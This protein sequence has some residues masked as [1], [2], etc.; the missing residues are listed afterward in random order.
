M[1]S[2]A[3]WLRNGL[4]AAAL[5]ASATSG[6]M[7]ADYLKK[8]DYYKEAPQF[9]TWPDP[10][11]ARYEIS[12]IGPIGLSLELI[13]PAFTMRISAVEPGSPAAATGQLRDPVQSN[14][15]R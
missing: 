5:T 12:R 15:N 4:M 13:Q 14:Q 9:H 8:D 2:A 7:A 11:A 3:R 1:N 6:L 10:A